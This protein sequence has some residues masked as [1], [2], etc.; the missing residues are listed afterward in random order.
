MHR[1]SMYPFT[2]VWRAVPND[3]TEQEHVDVE[4]N[5]LAKSET[6]IRSS[7]WKEKKAQKLEIDHAHAWAYLSYFGIFS[8]TVKEWL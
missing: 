1:K 2:N 7:W 8:Q 4:V 6:E 3:H 5:A